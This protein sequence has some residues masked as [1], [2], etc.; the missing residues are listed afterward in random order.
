MQNCHLMLRLARPRLPYSAMGSLRPVLLGLSIQRLRASEPCAWA[1][2]AM[3][4]EAQ[5]GPFGISHTVPIGGPK[6]RVGTSHTVPLE[7]QTPYSNTVL[8]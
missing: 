3:P 8:L 6:P 2:Q 7:A 4:W 1:S 5:T